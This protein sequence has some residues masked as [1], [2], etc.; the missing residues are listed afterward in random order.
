MIQALVGCADHLF[1]AEGNKAESVG[2]K[3]AWQCVRALAAIHLLMDANR[4]DPAQRNATQP[5]LLL[6]PVAAQP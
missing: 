6:R 4:F 1:R 2:Q 5:C 3:T